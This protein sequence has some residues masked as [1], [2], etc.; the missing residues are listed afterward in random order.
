MLQYLTMCHRILDCSIEND[1]DKVWI[2][3]LL[4]AAPNS[5]LRPSG[6]PFPT[7]DLKQNNH[8]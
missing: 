8:L 7:S 1:G 5:S 6:K 4:F 3:A 2:A